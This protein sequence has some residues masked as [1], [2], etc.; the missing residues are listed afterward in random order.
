MGVSDWTGR[1]V[2]Q[3]GANTARG[4]RRGD[5]G[6]GRDTSERARRAVPLQKQKNEAGKEK[7][8]PNGSGP[9]N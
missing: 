8:G 2:S 3:L 7:E 1:F 5:D 6:L 4:T 9:P